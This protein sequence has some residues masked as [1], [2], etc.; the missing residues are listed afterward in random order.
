MESKET[1]KNAIKDIFSKGKIT[2][3]LF[4]MLNSIAETANKFLE[5]DVCSIWLF[6]VNKN[7]LIL[8]GSSLKDS[9][10]LGT[11]YYKK[12]EGII[13]DIFSNKEIVII[14][15]E[16]SKNLWKGKYLN[17]I[18]P[19]MKNLGVP[20]LGVP[21][22]L[23]NTAIG[24]L[25]FSIENNEFNIPKRCIDSAK[26]FSDEISLTVDTLSAN[27]ENEIF[28]SHRKERVDFLAGFSFELLNC[29]SL[30]DII[31]LTCE[32]TRERLNCRTASIFLF[33]KE[34]FLERKYISGFNNYNNP[35]IEKYIRGQGLVGKTIGSVETYGTPQI[36][37]NFESEQLYQN[38]KLIRKHINNYKKSILK[39]FNI[40]E[41]IQHVASV[42]LNSFHR[43]AGVLQI[44]NKLKF[45]SNDLSDDGISELDKDWLLLIANLA[46][47]AIANFKMLK[48]RSLTYDINNYLINHP[49]NNLYRYLAKLI[50]SDITLYSNCTIRLF[51]KQ[52]H[53]LKV[54]GFAGKFK[55]LEF[56]V[57]R[58]DEGFV[59]K[60]FSNNKIS[61][62]QNFGIKSDGYIYKDWAL[63]NDFVTMICIP[64]CNLNKSKTYGTISIY[65]KFKFVFGK[66]DIHFLKDF[67]NQISNIIQIIHEKEEMELINLITDKI[68][69][70][71]NIRDI[72]Q[73][74][75]EELPILTGFDGCT[76][77][78]LEKNEFKI[79]ESTK[80]NVVGTKT[81]INETVFSELIACPTIKYFPKVNED[82]NLL[83]SKDLL[84]NVKSM[85]WIPICKQNKIF[86]I[87]ALISS[88][89][90]E[91]LSIER[92]FENQKSVQRI[93]LFKSIANLIG[94]AIEKSEILAKVKIETDN[95]SFINSILNKITIEENN[96]KNVKLI[97]DQVVKYLKCKIGYISLLTKKSN[98]VIPSYLNGI[99]LENFPQL[100]IGN[101]GIIG[102]IYKNGRK[103]AFIY[104]SNSQIDKLNTSYLKL[105]FAVNSELISPIVYNNAII[106]F[107]ALGSE[108]ENYFNNDHKSFIES[109]AEQTAN[110]IQN[111]KFHLAAL[112]LAATRFNSTNI[113][114]ICNLLAEKANKIL[115]TSVTCV[116]LKAFLE[117]KETLIMEGWS[118]AHIENP[119]LYNMIKN[120]SISWKTIENKGVEVI[121]EG[122][123]NEKSG[124]KHPQFAKENKLE[125]MI[126]MPMIFNDEA[127]G[128]INSYANRKCTFLD[129]EISLL[130]TL[131]LNGAATIKNSELN[132]M[133]LETAQLANPGTIAMSF[134]HDARHVIN[135]LNA[136]LSALIYLT[137]RSY[138]RSSVYQN[139]V[140]EITDESDYLRKLFD[141][142]VACARTETIYEENRIKD[143]LGFVISLYEIRLNRNR[144]SLK[145]FYER[146]VEDVIIECDKHQ[147]EQVFI[148]LF[149]NSLYAIKQKSHIVGLI[150][151]YIR[152]LNQDLIEIQFSDNGI[153]I[154]E[155]II[156]EIFKP[157][158]TT[159]G[160]NGSGFGLAICKHII[161]DNHI[162]TISVKS[163]YNDYT[164]FF[165]T[166]PKK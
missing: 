11:Y 101:Q 162:G 151:I 16:R 18:H 137:K 61:R 97:L 80:K 84:K 31:K 105:D 141:S 76:I 100:E 19:N 5:T 146:D 149:N 132:D 37:N 35:P 63:K 159:K 130:E 112:E 23:H 153:G 43:S 12:D 48:Y 2:N 64:I 145:L 154:Q 107:I 85:I 90:K 38:D 86:G 161:E 139:L 74:A 103:E 147:I 79:R 83:S 155:K 116:W 95:K 52:S 148:N 22:L 118:G 144:I 104:P 98:F 70:K 106:G 115:D 44:V 9:L 110:I 134:T 26:I 54:V 78:V 20:F 50:I 1:I 126:S 166:L 82:P 68:N 27:F 165:I 10:G 138:V 113:N 47:M 93:N 45:N 73:I 28:S 25:T 30:S 89:K 33:S 123:A 81:L 41:T 127:I 91:R 140:K 129:K 13:W 143:I 72:L 111:N 55:D 77:A 156:S 58:A 36:T 164:T 66:D 160:L 125:S 133:I 24:V 46:S 4:G 17:Y 119:S 39:E 56:P 128:V 65:T 131:A 109:I 94:T 3:A 34:G 152:S 40:V 49:D 75:V 87:L 57:L 7:S 121:I 142:L 96:I 59:G 120:G 117:G 88:Q 92:V 62:V 8:Y 135:N 29:K 67:T 69:K 150:N 136:L 32:R 51:D 163:I 53:K 42:P 158:F 122:L 157:F 71:D 102:W 114:S 108:K 60:T 21:I 15:R 14:D 6:N 124:Y 99:E